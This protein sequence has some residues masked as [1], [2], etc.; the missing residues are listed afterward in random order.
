MAP[1]C[2]NEP[3]LLHSRIQ[4]MLSTRSRA[5]LKDPWMMELPLLG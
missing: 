2:S 1:T 3:M 5:V 4:Q